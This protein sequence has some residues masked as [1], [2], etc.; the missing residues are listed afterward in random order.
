MIDYPTLLP[1]ESTITVNLVSNCIDSKIVLISDDSDYRTWWANN[2]EI[3]FNFQVGQFTP[4]VFQ[5]P[6]S[7]QISASSSYTGDPFCGKLKFTLTDESHPTKLK[8][9]GADPSLGYYPSLS[10]YANELDY[11]QEA[12]LNVYGVYGNDRLI[13]SD[14]ALV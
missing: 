5:A 8:L 12:D 4:R 2:D 1:L 10:L 9:V 7:D 3:N 13:E 6:V 14:E 11:V